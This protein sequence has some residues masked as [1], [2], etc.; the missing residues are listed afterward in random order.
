MLDQMTRITEERRAMDERADRIAAFSASIDQISQLLG[1]PG[2][3]EA[4]GDVRELAAAVSIS[5]ERRA[6][7]PGLCDGPHVAPLAA[8]EGV[9]AAAA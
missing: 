3:E 8:A 5:K 1:R 6:L 9:L 4:T 2:A 7:V